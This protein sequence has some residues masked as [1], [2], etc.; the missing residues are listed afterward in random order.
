M[1]K[2]PTSLTVIAVILIVLAAIGLIGVFVL[3]ST[4]QGRQ[5]LAQ[6]HMSLPAYQALGVVGA[7]V[8]VACAYGILKGLPWS[9]VLYVVWGIIGL[10]IGFYTSPMKAGIV[11]NLVI[12]IVI[13]VFL[14]TNNANDWFQAR[15]LMLKRE[16]RGRK[17]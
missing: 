15:G 2:R 12:L 16:E 13:S 3:A 17:G 6:T 5:A 14:W 7:I 4:A 8:T 10:A 1:E 11:L 9:R